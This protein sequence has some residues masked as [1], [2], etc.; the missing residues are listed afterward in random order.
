MSSRCSLRLLVVEQTRK[1]AYLSGDGW[2]SS[3]GSRKAD[4]TKRNG[5]RLSA[6][7]WWRQLWS[8]CLGDCSQI[9]GRDTSG[10]PFRECIFNGRACSVY[11]WRAAARTTTSTVLKATFQILP[12]WWVGSCHFLARFIDPCHVILNTALYIAKMWPAATNFRGSV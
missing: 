7:R 8:E 9:S 1:G 12:S 6:S 10:V 4:D 2:R 3:R 5:A 11:L